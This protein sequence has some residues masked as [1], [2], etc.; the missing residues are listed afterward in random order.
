[1]RC[2][3]SSGKRRD[4]TAVRRREKSTELVFTHIYDP[5]EESR[6]H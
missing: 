5:E 2:R 4:Y 1:M 6:M 3:V